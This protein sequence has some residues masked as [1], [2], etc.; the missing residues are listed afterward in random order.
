MGSTDKRRAWVFALCV[1]AMVACVVLLG[2]AGA[3][4][5]RPGDRGRLGEP[6]SRPGPS[7]GQVPDPYDRS[8]VARQALAFTDAYLAYEVGELGG[9]ARRTLSALSTRGF[10]SQLLGARPGIPPGGAPAREWAAR[11]V[12]L[13][14]G[15]FEGGPALLVGV[16][17]IGVNGSHVL[18]PTLVK[19]GSRWLVGGIGA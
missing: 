11:V 17:V 14:V 18:T 10:A 6:G 13:H 1:G 7:G 19:R 2:R 16:L 4:G 9:S 15:I 12:S 8:A 5:E 3:G